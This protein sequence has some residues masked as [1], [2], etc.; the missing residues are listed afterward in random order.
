MMGEKKMLWEQ[1]NFLL[2]ELAAQL[3]MGT[4]MLS[5]MERGE[6]YLSTGK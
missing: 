2:R 5:K 6:R 1:D 3:E 4:A